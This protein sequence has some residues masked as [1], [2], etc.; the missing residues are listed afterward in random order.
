M[1]ATQV[2]GVTQMENM[3]L[4]DGTNLMAAIAQG[5]CNKLI[6]TTSLIGQK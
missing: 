1:F 5:P 3:A 2:F 4:M 6:V